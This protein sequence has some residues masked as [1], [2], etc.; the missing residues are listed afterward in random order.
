M[1]KKTLLTLAAFL[2]LV[3]S[4]YAHDMFLKLT[5]YFLAPHTDATIAL[6]NGT[7]DKS[8]NVVTRDRMQDV[9]IVG[10]GDEAV[11]PDTAQWREKDNTTW[12]DFKTG[13]PGTYVIGV[14][15]LPRFIDLSA[16]EFNAYLEHDGVL[17]VLEARKRE[18]TL[19]KPARER[20]SKHV[21]AIFQVGDQRTDAYQHR[22]GYPIEIVP[23]KNP[24]ALGV[25]DTFEVLVLKEGQPVADQLVYASYEGYHSHDEAGEHDEAGGHAEAVKTRT[26]EDGVA[27]IE[28]LHA[29]Q[30]YVRLIH[31]V[32]ADEEE[33]DYE[34]NWTTLTFEVKSP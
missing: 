34:S 12:L 30:W 33:V 2:L 21:K 19:D 28:L 27:R 13:A 20:Y 14:S 29:G 32:A 1:R 9:R 17:D 6:F 25:G 7:F 23:L 24:Y 3:G 18:G 10:P 5:T 22:L 26:D 11:H 15:T 16:E 31:I 4:L 8:E